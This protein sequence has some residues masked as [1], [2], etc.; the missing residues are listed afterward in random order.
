MGR[1]D[2][3]IMIDISRNENYAKSL[4]QMQI[5]NILTRMQEAGGRRGKEKPI[6]H[7]RAKNTQCKKRKMRAH[8]ITAVRG[9]R[10]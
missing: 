2:S 4:G 7:T 5:W 6:S 8:S 1:S 10:K 3:M 9:R